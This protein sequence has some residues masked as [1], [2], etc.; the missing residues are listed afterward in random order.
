MY[1]M[2]SGVGNLLGYLGSGW[3]SRHC[4]RPEGMLWSLFWGGLALVVALVLANF[5]LTYRGVNAGWTRNPAGAI[6]G[7]R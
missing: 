3:W 5:L 6:P 2:T 1:L 4:A 7:G